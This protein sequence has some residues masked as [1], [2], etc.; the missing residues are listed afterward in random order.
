MADKN[1]EE[2]YLDRLIQNA[3]NSDEKIEQAISETENTVNEA[4]DDTEHIIEEN[5]ND[6]LSEMAATDE[7]ITVEED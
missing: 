5:N 4:I 6:F 3:M 2:E 1:Q 7:K